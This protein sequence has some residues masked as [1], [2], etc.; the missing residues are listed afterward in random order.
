VRKVVSRGAGAALLSDITALQQIVEAVKAATRIPITA[1]IRLGWDANS[2][3]VVEAAQAIESGGADALTVHARTRSQ[4]YSGKASWEYIAQVKEACRIPVIGNGDVFDGPSAA[5][6]FQG[7][8]VDG[9]MIARGALGQ[10]WIFR[11]ILHYLQEWKV[12]PI[13]TVNER[14]RILQKH[15]RLEVAEVGETMALAQMRKNFTWYTHGLPHSAHLRDQIFHAASYQEI[16]EIFS[17]FLKLVRPVEVQ[18]I[19]V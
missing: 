7:T 14:I 15:Y 1:K 10:P 18:S 5:Q 2:I 13:P 16:E 6:M 17:S 12:T 11:H 3:V 4:G 19:T 8:G 9:I